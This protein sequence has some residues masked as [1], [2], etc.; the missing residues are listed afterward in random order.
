[1]PQLSIDPIANGG[2]IRG[3]TPLSGSATQ[4]S[5][6]RSVIL[7]VD[8][9]RAADAVEANSRWLAHIDASSLLPG[10]HYLTV[11]A[12]ANDGTWSQETLSVVAVK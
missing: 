2:V 3:V 7:Y 10:V 5:G 6:I 12:H 9:K 11:M 8:A 4:A 1:M